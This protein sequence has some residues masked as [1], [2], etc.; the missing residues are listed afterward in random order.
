MVGDLCWCERD[1]LS[2]CEKAHQRE[3]DEQNNGASPKSQRENGNQPPSHL[4]A[5]VHDL[6]AFNLLGSRGFSDGPLA[7]AGSENGKQHQYC[8][9]QC[10]SFL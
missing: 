10:V 7:V 2:E 5:G 4:D 6:D 9:H 8:Q 3:D 1:K